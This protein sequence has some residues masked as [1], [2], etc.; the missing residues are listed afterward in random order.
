[1]GSFYTDRNGSSR[2]WLAVKAAVTP[3][4]FRF[5]LQDHRTTVM[6]VFL[7]TL[8]NKHRAE[9]VFPLISKVATLSSSECCK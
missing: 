8:D 4:I 5:F 1:M 3:E 6:C 7:S 9:G 2:M